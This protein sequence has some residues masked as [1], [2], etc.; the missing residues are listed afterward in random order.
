MILRF[1]NYEKINGLIIVFQSNGIDKTN[2]VI[3]GLYF[4]PT[5]KNFEKGVFPYPSA[6][7][8]RTNKFK[9][10]D[11]RYF[12]EII[13]EKIFYNEKIKKWNKWT[14]WS[15]NS[16]DAEIKNYLPYTELYSDQNSLL[17]MLKRL[18]SVYLKPVNRF[19]GKGILNI[20][21]TKTGYVVRDTSYNKTNFKEAKELFSFLQKK[22]NRKYIIQQEIDAHFPIGKVDFRAYFFK[23]VKKEWYFAAMETKIAPKDSII[24][25]HKNR[26]AMMQGETALREIYGFDTDKIEE[27]KKKIAALCIKTLKTA[28][29]NGYHFGEAAIDL[30]IDVNLNIWLLETQTFFAAEGKANR[31]EDERRVLPIILPAPFEYAKGLAGF[32][33]R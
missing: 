8:N 23:D 33:S 9:D 28:E 31:T 12:R 13:G 18:S 5:N 15:L 1:L 26:K 6:I 22:I 24:T 17:E 3:R 19:G 2:K 32:S 30:V 14:F 29:I 7:Y 25:N 21:K 27:M 20:E 16:K 11:I 4:N 10:Q